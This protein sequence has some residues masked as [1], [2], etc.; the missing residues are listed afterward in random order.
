M[1]L[2][3]QLVVAASLCRLDPDSIPL[4]TS[5]L[6]SL[7]SFAELLALA[8]ALALAQDRLASEIL[9]LGTTKVVAA[10][11]ASPPLSLSPIAHMP[12]QSSVPGRRL[13]LLLLLPFGPRR[14][15]LSDYCNGTGLPSTYRQQYPS[16]LGKNAYTVLVHPKPIVRQV[17]ECVGQWQG[18]GGHEVQARWPP[19]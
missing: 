1:W 18:S 3:R 4:F 17:P 5:N 19:G 16:R 7:T 14:L 11:C 13:L 6:A 9:A 15:C 12:N 8:L 10:V 2:P